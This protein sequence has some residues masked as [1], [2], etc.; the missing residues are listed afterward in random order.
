[1]DSI[2]FS[3]EAFVTLGIEIFAMVALP[4]I[5]LIIWKVKTKAKILP[6]IVGAV[7]FPVFALGLKMI[8]S[9][10]LMLN[11]SELANTVMENLWLQALVGALLA[12]IFEESGRFI[13]FKFIL[14]KCGD[15][16]NAISYGIGHGGFECLYLGYAALVYLVMGI[17]I[18]NGNGAALVAGADEYTAA[19]AVAQM[20]SAAEMKVGV[21]FIAIWERL[22]A[23]MLHISLSV[24]VF[25]AVKKK[26]FGWMYPLSILLHSLADF[27]IGFY[28]TGVI[29]SVIVLELVMTALS[30]ACAVIAWRVYKTILAPKPETIAE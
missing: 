29:S 17:M 5:L 14:K 6:V 27:T 24:L 4:I 12:G 30:G 8:P 19:A 26:G 7:I 1:M 28:T 2:R 9:Y 23:L 13:A 15:R 11:G 21:A 25:A 3:T 22:S 10:F 16:V 20:A 18:N